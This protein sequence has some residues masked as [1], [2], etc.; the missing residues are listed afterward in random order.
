MFAAT[1]GKIL[2]NFPD[3][4]IEANLTHFI[5]SDAHNVHNRT[6]KM[7]EAFEQVE[8]SYGMDMVYLFRENAE[9]LVQGKNVFKEI[10]EKVQR[11]KFLGIF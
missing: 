2:R 9:L 4:L 8:K 3:Q 7:V 1:L 10:P 6:F 5:A 11:K